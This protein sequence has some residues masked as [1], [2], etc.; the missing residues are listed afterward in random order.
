MFKSWTSQAL[1][2]KIMGH[3]GSSKSEAQLDWLAF[4]SNI[5]KGVDLG[6]T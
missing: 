6:L 1:S 4:L 3:I 5:T 2:S